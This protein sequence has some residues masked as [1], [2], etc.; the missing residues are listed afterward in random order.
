ME[1]HPE[2]IKQQMEETRES[3]SD[4]LE[5]LEQKVLSTVQD[6]T[7]TVTQTVESVADAVHS[8]VATV[9]EG[10]QEGV[11]K[12]KETIDLR[13][14]VARHPWEMFLGSIATGFAAGYLLTPSQPCVAEPAAAQPYVPREAA[15]SGPAQPNWMGQLAQ[16]LEPVFS[17]VKGLAIGAAV[18]VVGQMVMEAAP[19]AWRQELPALIDQVTT[20]LGGKPMHDTHFNGSASATSAAYGSRT[21]AGVEG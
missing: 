4:K 5:V 10:V 18:D 2:V 3:L 12:V 19:P 1:Q 14:Q 6:T 13:L 21:R 8:T 7:D 17:K 9:K 11:E 15:A 20:A 16:Q